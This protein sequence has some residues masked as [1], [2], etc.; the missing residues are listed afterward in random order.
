MKITARDLVELGI[1]NGVVP[2]PLG[3]A[4]RD[5]AEAAQLLTSAIGEG[6]DALVRLPTDELL[7]RRYEKYRDIAFFQE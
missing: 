3:G 6:L 1:V 5:R 4:H 7:A 2:E